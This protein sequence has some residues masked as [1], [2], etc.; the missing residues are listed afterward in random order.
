M[1]AAVGRTTAA[2]MGSVVM[3]AAGPLPTA[4]KAGERLHITQQWA[5]VE[6][7]GRDD[8]VRP[9]LLLPCHLCCIAAAPFLLLLPLHFEN[10]CGTT[11]SL[12]D[13]CI[14][15]CPSNAAVS[16]S[17]AAITAHRVDQ[18]PRQSCK[19]LHML[20]QRCIVN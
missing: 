10:R 6:R 14:L 15:S 11:N 17:L 20:L 1:S 4:L 19:V 7:H 12:C 18:Q 13:R 16:L 2:E 8:A 5:A 9:V 3:G